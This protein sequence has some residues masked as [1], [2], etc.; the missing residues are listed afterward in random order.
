MPRY[1]VQ[2]EAQSWFVVDTLSARVIKKYSSSETASEVAEC[3]N[4]DED[5][6]IFAEFG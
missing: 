2:S 4:W 1:I 3:K 5:Q 6:E